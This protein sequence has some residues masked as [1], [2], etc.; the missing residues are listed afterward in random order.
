[1]AVTSFRVHP[2]T[3]D[4]AWFFTA[5]FLFYHIHMKT[6]GPGTRSAQMPDPS[7]R[8][9]SIPV[10]LLHFPAKALFEISH[11]ALSARHSP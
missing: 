7:G 5:V 6:E 11:P 4:R 2:Y 8:L 3:T 10:F 1:M 9:F